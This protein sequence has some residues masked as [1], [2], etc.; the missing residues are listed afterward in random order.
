MK[1]LI[2]AGGTGTRLWPLSRASKPKQVQPF[3]NNL[4]LLQHT[5]QRLRTSFSANDIFVSTSQAHLKEILVQLPELKKSHL[6]V[7]P[8]ARNTAPAI[9]LAAKVIYKLF[10]HEAVATINSDQYIKEVSFFIKT[11][12]ICENVIKHSPNSLV[13]MGI[14]P[15]YAET[16]YGYIKLGRKLKSGRKSDSVYKVL[17][18]TEKPSLALAKRL[19]IS[20]NHLWNSGM[21]VFYPASLFKMY[22]VHAAGLANKLEKL[23]IK[24]FK[25][26]VW[27]VDLKQFSKLTPISIDY[28]LVERAKNELIVVPANFGWSDVGHWRTIYS[29]LSANLGKNI[30]RGNYLPF[31]SKGNLVYTDKN[32]LVATVGM[33]AFIVVDTPDAL[34]ICP[35]SQAQEV[36]GVVEELKKRGWHKY[37]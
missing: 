25:N 26:K 24:Q 21:F 4:T 9:G 10:P 8:I 7:E 20:K 27:S 5:W 30:V 15:S 31:N 12:K 37:I 34:L 22:R 29:I 18:F 33:D 14:K 36:K 32:K 17:N 2:L 11:L 16:G 35:Q 1:L 3:L 28:A 6:I 23:K 19:V 13:L